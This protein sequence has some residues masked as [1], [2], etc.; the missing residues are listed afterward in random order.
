MRDQVAR[1]GHPCAAGIFSPKTFLAPAIPI[2]WEEPDLRGGMKAGRGPE[3]RRRVP[4][5]GPT[6]KRIRAN[7]RKMSRDAAEKI[8]LHG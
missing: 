6:S 4:V 5:T 1:I 7:L 8:P 3:F 2:S